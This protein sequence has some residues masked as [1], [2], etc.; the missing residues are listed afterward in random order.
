MATLWLCDK[1][2]RNLAEGRFPPLPKAGDES[3]CQDILT[4]LLQ[5]LNTR[6]I[7]RMVFAP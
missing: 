3:N 6:F 7:V 2:E 5:S 4:W 1:G